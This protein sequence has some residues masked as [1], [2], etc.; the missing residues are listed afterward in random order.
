MAQS[1]S[2]F[3]GVYTSVIVRLSFLTA[4][5][6]VCEAFMHDQEY[7]NITCLCSHQHALRSQVPGMLPVCV[8]FSFACSANYELLEK[9]VHMRYS[10][11]GNLCKNN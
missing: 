10:L 1:G 9:Y 4:T 6:V 8:R 3:L 11:A 5:G 2:K 7:W